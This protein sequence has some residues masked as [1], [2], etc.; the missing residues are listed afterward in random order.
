MYGQADISWNELTSD[1][2][3]LFTKDGKYIGDNNYKVAA[4]E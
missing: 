4:R 3:Y 1:Y 2:P